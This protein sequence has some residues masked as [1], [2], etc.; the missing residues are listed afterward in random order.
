MRNLTLRLVLCFLLV[1]NAY[2]APITYEQVLQQQKQ[3]T[4]PPT[5]TPSGNPPA[6]QSKA[7]EGGDRPEFVHLADGRIVPFGP[8]V[9]CSDDCVQ[10]EALAPDDPTDLRVP[11]GIP[12]WLWITPGIIGGI[13]A[14]AAL[15]NGGDSSTVVTTDEP[16]RIITPPPTDVP[17][18]ATLMLLGL[19]LAIIA[20]HGFGKKKSDDK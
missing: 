19:G 20:R 1:V 16:P 4:P 10:S 5:T 13:I 3:A 12:R 15:C 11:G 2:A 7:T 17:E 14:C 6:T 18:P 9:I 8:G